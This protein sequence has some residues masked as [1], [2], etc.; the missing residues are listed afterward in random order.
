M[1]KT[2]LIVLTVG[3]AVTGLSSCA[4]GYAGPDNS[5]V[6]QSV[7]SSNQDPRSGPVLVKSVDMNGYYMTTIKFCD[8][9]TLVYNFIGNSKGGG[10]VIESSPECT[11]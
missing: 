1:R 10:A 9:T 2:A 6:N 7:K 3:M 4:S 5:T 11:S 8:G